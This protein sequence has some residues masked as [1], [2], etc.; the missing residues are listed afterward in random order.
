MI[1]QVLENLSIITSFLLLAT[2]LILLTSCNKS[3]KNLK[4]NIEEEKQMIRKPAVAGQ[5]YPANKDELKNQIASFLNNAEIVDAEKDLRILI[6]PHAGYTYSGQVAAWG[7]KQLENKNYQKVI[8]LGASHRAYFDK[9]GV[10]DKGKWQT[11]LGN[12]DIDENVAENLINQ[13]NNISSNLAVHEQEHSLEVEIPFIQ[14]VLPNAEIVPIL[15]GHQNKQVIDDLAQTITN[16]FDNNTLLVISTDLSHYPDYGTAN[17]VDNDTIQAIL[18]GDIE[19]F[20][21]TI[22][23]NEKKQAVDTCACGQDAIRVAM[24][25]AKKLEIDEIKLLK[26]ANSGDFGTDKSRVV[27]YAAIGYYG[28]LQNS[29]TQKLQTE[30]N[31]NQQEELLT[32]A[33]QTLE[34]YLENKKIP[35]ITVEDP[36]L[37]E[38]LGA[39][40]TLRKNGELRGCIGQFEPDIPLYKVV[41]Q[42]AVDAATNDPR[43]SPVKLEELDEIT[44][45]I[46][47]MSPKTKI[48]DWKEIELGKH[49]V[50]VRKGMRSGTFLPQ[51]ATETGWDLETFLSRLCSSKAGLSP[52]CY[53]D[54][55]VDLYVF[56]AHVFEEK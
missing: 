20:N 39:F 51:V 41:Q 47:A 23:A 46:S 25:I 14:T 40:V 37:Q 29:K 10:Y 32:I 27:G 33:R 48:D 34:E 15:L 28:K 38:N 30:L 36:T 35:E 18:S 2:T 17:K 22:E 42:K 55:S 11:P 12:I 54:K 19:K 21:K 52:N 13:S 44:I 16:K 6:V 7:F 9:A 3:D 4:L 56:T 49:G 1:K 45:E 43:F 50:V 5:F 53:K 24:Q 31:K 8:I 26:Y